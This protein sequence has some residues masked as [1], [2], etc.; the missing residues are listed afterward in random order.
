[1]KHD[2]IDWIA[3]LA[4]AVLVAMVGVLVT[5]DDG[6]LTLRTDPPG[7]RGALLDS[8]ATR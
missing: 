6:N 2:W 3:A 8:K 4:L 5:D 7:L 1:M